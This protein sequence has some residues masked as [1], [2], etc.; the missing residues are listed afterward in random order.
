MSIRK[1][2]VPLIGHQG[3]EE[4]KVA[5]ESAVRVGFTF[6]R[7]LGAHVEV[8][9]IAAVWHDQ[10]ELLAAAF[11][12]TAIQALLSEV[13]KRN[14]KGFWLARS[15][16]DQLA[17]DFNPRR[18]SEP[19]V[20]PLFSAE[21]LEITGEISSVAAEH[22]KLA[23]LSVIASQPKGRST[24]HDLLVQ[25][26]LT[27]TGRPLMVVPENCAEV[28]LGKIAIAWNDT[29]ES[30]RAVAMTMGFIRQASD[31]LIITV[32]EDGALPSGPQALADYLLW[33]GVQAKVVEVSVS[34]QGVA[35]ALLNEADKTKSGLLIMGAYT[36]SKL[37]RILFGGATGGALAACPLPLLLVD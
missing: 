1:I 19:A 12:E 30:A 26:L 28:D 14:D 16:F 18:D 24:Q 20:E 2:H 4:L 35:E 34:G 10:D 33:H 21:F 17:A 9:C 22:G 37:Q 29:N 8:C 15:L 6:G 31:V 27:D 23:D 25:T 36:R 5:S 32:L 3:A 11:P 7:D 13:K